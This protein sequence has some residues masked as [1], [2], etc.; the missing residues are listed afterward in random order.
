MPTYYVDPAATGLNDGSSWENA[1]TSINSALALSAVAAGDTVYCRGSQTLSSVPTNQNAGSLSGGFIKFIG[2]NASGVNDG[3]YFVLNANSAVANAWNNNAKSY[4]WLENLELKNATSHGWTRSANSYW[5]QCVF[6]NVYSHDN[7]G[8]GFECYY[9]QG[10]LSPVVWFRCKAN[11]NGGSGFYDNYSGFFVWY[12]CEAIGNSSSGIKCR[13]NSTFLGVMEHCLLHQNTDNQVVSGSSSTA[14]VSG[15]VIDG[16]LNNG[17]STT[18][19]LCLVIGGR[20]TNHSVAT[21]LG[22]ESLTSA[23]YLIAASYLGGNTTDITAGSYEILTIN[24]STSDMT[25]GGTDSDHGYT[26]SANDN[27]NLAP[28]ATGR[29]IAIPLD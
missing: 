5:G 13:G 27:F 28:G 3:T 8:N 18:N 14:F 25:F 2:C 4:I 15:S 26:D 17:I 6:V 9:S 16:G 29:S 22:L 19:G 24:G 1:W 12:G 11:N 10:P 23:K 21:K 7:G 20:I